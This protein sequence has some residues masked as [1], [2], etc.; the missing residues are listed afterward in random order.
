[1]FPVGFFHRLDASEAAE[2]RAPGLRRS[3][4]LFEVVLNL[5]FQMEA[6]FRIQLALGPL[7]L[8]QAAQPGDDQARPT[9]PCSRVRLAWSFF[10]G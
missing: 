5:H 6:D 4:A 8:E 7:L 10:I 9:H 2:G 1:M 3:H